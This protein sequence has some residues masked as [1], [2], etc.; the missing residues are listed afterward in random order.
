MRSSSPTPTSGCFSPFKNIFGRSS[1][2]SQR[3]ASSS[4]SVEKATSAPSYQPSARAQQ[5]AGDLHGCC[6]SGVTPSK[7]EESWEGLPSYESF[8]SD[9]KVF[10]PEVRQTIKEAI[11]SFDAPLRKLSLYISDHPE[12]NY[13]EFKAHEA[14]TSY[15]EKEGFAVERSWGGLATAFKATF[16]LKG[17]GFKKER[18]FGINSEYDALPGV[19]H[20]CG[21]NLIAISGVAA[22][23]GVREAMRK[24]SIFGT[25]V[26]I[27]TPAE[28]GGG[29]KGALIELGAYKGLDACMMLHPTPGPLNSGGIGSS[30]AVQ[31]VSVEFFGKTAHA[32]AAPWEGI[33]ALDAAHLAYGSV[34]ALRQQMKP[35]ARVHGIITDGGLAPNVIPEHSAMKY[36][37]RSPKAE[38][39]TALLERV[40]NC[41]EA[42]AEATGCTFKVQKD[43][44][45]TDLRNSTVL[46]RE[47][48]SAM[49]DLF[50]APIK[51][52]PAGGSTDFGNVTYVVP[53]CHPLF[54]I[55]SPAGSGNH[56]I[57]FTDAARTA[58]AHKCTLEAATG[59]AI[60][61]ARILADESFAN[62]ARSA[63]E[64][65]MRSA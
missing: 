27:G 26:L 51:A 35:D 13:Q 31:M 45:Y 16:S 58:E 39:V 59:L 11:L 43:A 19:G 38:E 18:T 30:L 15:L 37:V 53:G 32:A 54:S 42:A 4:P 20:A 60:T 10:A 21:H 47:Y 1:S 50:G 17:D 12:L 56:T 7:N 3:T 49:G 61:G 29:G 25:V 8:V 64:K 48:T 44:L 24:H 28:E 55:N 5:L 63:W 65:D 6:C 23:L 2:S 36:C 52:Q 33:N 22:L 62:E 14:M 9:D 34:S 57:G 46:G 41:F 40:V